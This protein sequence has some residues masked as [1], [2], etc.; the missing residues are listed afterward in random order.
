MV[1]FDEDIHENIIQEIK[2]T[3]DVNNIEEDYVIF[4]NDDA[5]T[6]I[7]EGKDFIVSKISNVI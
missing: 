6:V 5:Y 2:E 7:Q 1:I 3:I 4:V